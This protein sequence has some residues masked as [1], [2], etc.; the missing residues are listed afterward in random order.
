MVHASAALAGST[1]NP[2]ECRLLLEENVSSGGKTIKEQ[3]FCLDLLKAYS[4]GEEFALSHEYWSAYRI[5]MLAARALRSLGVDGNAVAD[6][7]ALRKVCSIANGH[8]LH[9]GTIPAD[10]IY[11]DSLYIHFIVSAQQPWA[12][13]ND[14]MGRLLMNY[15]QMECGLAPVIVR[16]S[17]RAEYKRVLGIA[18][19]E[20][21][22]VVFVDYMMDHL[23]DAPEKEKSVPAAVTA[24]PALKAA[25]G[26]KVHPADGFAL[27]QS[28]SGRQ[29]PSSR[30]M[31]LA[32]LRDHPYMTTADL[33]GAIGISA[34]GVE[35]QLRLLKESG[36]LERIG[37]DKGGHW[38]VI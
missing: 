9:L 19:E 32:L 10:E 20:D 5:K 26:Q 12:G 11:R 17:Q 28:L 38:R 23:H 4:L 21:I 25:R 35:K 7:A 13:G 29:N 37:P 1:L 33:A 6:E 27:S 24:S 16:P 30:Q 18:K 15:L 3:L 14:V 22:A 36:R 34:K 2:E 8:R 31:I